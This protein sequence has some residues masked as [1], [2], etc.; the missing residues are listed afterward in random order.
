[1]VRDF[2]HHARAADLAFERLQRPVMPMSVRAHQG[3]AG[4]PQ[5]PMTVRRRGP[6]TSLPGRREDWLAE[7][8]DQLE[9]SSGA[10][11]G[12]SEK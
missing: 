5:M 6:A 10:T 2:P 3:Y 4:D 11:D 1:M 7:R 9:W 8:G 12:S